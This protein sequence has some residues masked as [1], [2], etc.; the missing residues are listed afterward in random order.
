MIRGTCLCGAVSFEVAEAVEFRYC[1]CSRCRKARGSAFAA[2]IFTRP[3]GFKWLN[4][5]DRL[6][7]Y[8]VPTAER[9]SNNFCKTCGSPMPQLIA[10]LGLVLVPAGTLDEDPGLRPASHIFVGSKAPW[11]K[12]TD[13][14]PQH[15]KYP[16]RA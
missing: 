9:F 7:M 11:D 12:I 14:L 16:P 6:T 15:E 4:G 13:A 5:E 3:E 8:R 2:N 10:S 1:N